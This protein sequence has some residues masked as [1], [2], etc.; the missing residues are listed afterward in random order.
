[1]QKIIDYLLENTE[2]LE[3]VVREINS[4]N[5]SLSNLEAFPNDEDFFDIFFGQD[6]MGAVRAVQYGDYNINDDYVG[7]DGYGNLV[8]FNYREYIDELKSEVEEIVELL[9]EYHSEIYISDELKELIDKY[10]RA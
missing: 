5:G 8:S 1:M 3:D 4:W 6:V 7:F 9:V 10:E 2:E